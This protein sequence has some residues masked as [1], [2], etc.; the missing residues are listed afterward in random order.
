[1]HESP[2]VDGIKEYALG[3]W[4]EF[5]TLTNDLFSMLL[6]NLDTPAEADGLLQCNH[7]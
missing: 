4:T 7:R 5:F 1:M 3:S 2:T 6:Q